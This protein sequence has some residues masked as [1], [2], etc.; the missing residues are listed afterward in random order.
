MKEKNKII[1]SISILLIISIIMPV[2]LFSNPKKARALAAVVEAG[3][4]WTIH[5]TDMFATTKV[6]ATGTT[7]TATV[8]NKTWLEKLKEQILMAIAKKA[9]AE[10]TKSTINWI[11]SGFHG[12]PLFLENPQSFFKDIAKYEVRTVVDQFGY[13]SL[14]YPFGKSFALNVINSY[15]RQLSD[16]TAYTL[17]KVMT[18]EEAYNFRVNFNYGGWN[19][20]LINT[21]YPQNNYLG[22]QMTASDY[23]A[24]QIQGTANTAVN[25]VKSTLQQGMGFLSPQKCTTN[26]AYNNGTN[27][28][29]QPSF[30]QDAWEKD[31]LKNN[32]LPPPGDPQAIV[33]WNQIHEDMLNGAIGEW[34]KKNTCPKKADGTSGFESETPG[35]VAANQVMKALT[36]G[37]TQT[38]LQQALGNSMSA[39]FDALLNHFFDK[40]LNSLA[41]KI[42][43]PSPADNWSYNGY[44]L[45]SPTTGTSSTGFNWNSP[46][47]VVVLSELKASV[48]NAINNTA[49]SIK[50][51]DNTDADNPGVKQL[52]SQIST[53]TQELDQCLPGP[54]IGWEDRLEIEKGRNDEKI[55]NANVSE[56]KAL[57]ASNDLKL[58]V[59]SF[60]NW[61]TNK[62]S[63]DLPGSS[64]Y[65]DAIGDIK[66][67]SEQVTTLMNQK[68]TLADALLKLQSIKDSLDLIT[69]QPAT[70]SIEE[71]NLIDLKKRY[72]E[73]NLEILSSISLAD[74]QNELQAV[75][76]KIKNLGTLTTKCNTERTAKGYTASSETGNTEQGLFCDAPIIGGYSHG[77]F[78]NSGKITHPEIKLV[79]AKIDM[80]SF[81]FIDININCNTIYN[82]SISDYK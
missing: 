1:K 17:S 51:M 12:A 47:V 50:L 52:F 54:D 77:L 75:K 39:I 71:K 29:N 14:K 30:N 36:S 42:N 70:G 82:A 66:N 69:T 45:G 24:K 11:N 7:T 56:D 41:S 18:Q 68:Q 61:I 13:D 67:I 49:L 38:E 8:Q 33:A 10:M 53:K 64:S 55:Q 25:E 72:D 21:Q 81:S 4:R 34:A 63:A 58:A 35:A 32:S 5:L 62:M 74:I 48:Q 65:L 79:N 27:E 37:Q 20:F 46:D 43:P 40:G 73:V 60:K 57:E 59:D 76:D 23:L 15:K 3:P 44:T 16:N 22:F 2:V 31:Y 19:G 6:I 26:S 9:L 80:G 28:F 78:V